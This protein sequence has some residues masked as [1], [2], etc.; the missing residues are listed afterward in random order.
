MT[1]PPELV[2]LAQTIAVAAGDLIMGH[3]RSATL[4]VDHKADGSFVT[5]AD[6]EAEQY[7]RALID[8]HC[9]GDGIIGEEYDEVPSSTGRTWI[10][11]PIDGTLSFVH[12]VPLFSTLIGIR[13]EAGPLAGVI[14]AP[15]VDEI[16]VAGRG[17]GCLVNGVP[18]AMSSTATLAEATVLTSG[19]A[20]YW[21]PEVLERLI[22]CGARVRTWAD[23]GYAHVLLA[24][25][26]VDA[27]VEPWMNLWDVAPV[28]CLIPEAGGSVAWAD[29]GGRQGYVASNGAHRPGNCFVIGLANPKTVARAQ[30]G[31][32]GYDP[33]HADR[34]PIG[35]TR[36]R[37]SNEGS[38][39]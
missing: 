5:V 26:R 13:D 12:G 15:A 4:E 8:Q 34:E 19:L 29:V 18:A 23:G 3:F 24:S 27:V 28:E 6:K 21:P 35:L 20:D 22:G 11:D 37:P 14:H 38:S 16:A 30:F 25:G 17:L 7:I 33:P 36:K 10:I 31:Q 39:V 1:A 9:P 32:W 2:D